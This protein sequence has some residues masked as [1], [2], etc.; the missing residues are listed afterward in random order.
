MTKFIELRNTKNVNFL[1]DFQS[2]WEIYPGEFSR[3]PANWVNH[4][5]GRNL[6]CALTYQEIKTKLDVAGL[7]DVLV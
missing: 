6:N 2:G 4:K 3:S 1:I 7:Y 5:E